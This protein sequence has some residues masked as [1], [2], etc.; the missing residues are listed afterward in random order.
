VL[1]IVVAA[2]GLDVTGSLAS[3]SGPDDAG[4]GPPPNDALAADAAA[5]VASRGDAPGADAHVATYPEVV[6]ADGPIH[7]WRFEEAAAATTIADVGQPGG[8]TGQ[9]IG[10]VTLGEASAFASLGKSARFDGNETVG[11]RIDLGLFH[12]GDSVTVELWARLDMVVKSYHSV[13]ARWDGSYELDV[14]GATQ[15]ANF[16][17]HDD[18]VPLLLVQSAQDYTRDAWHHMVGVFGQGNVTLYLDGV[19]GSTLP[20]SGNLRN[21]GP[22]PDHVFIGATRLG[23]NGGSY[24]WTGWVDEVAVYAK[25]LGAADVSRHFAAAR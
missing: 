9:V 14:N 25:A 20:T 6:L 4:L 5:D 12:P 22:T 21:A 16:V 17:A 3:P 15:R 19:P 13:F 10:N 2:C 11:S 23:S 24:N 8:I 1:A 18:T 7:Y